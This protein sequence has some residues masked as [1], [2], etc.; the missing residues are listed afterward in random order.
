[1]EEIK[2][3]VIDKGRTYLYL[4]YTDPTTGKPVEK[5]A[6]TSKQADGIQRSRQMA[7]WIAVGDTRNRIAWRGKCSGSITRRTPCRRSHWQPNNV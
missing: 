3:Y 5:S 6:R 2:V 1:M 7:G 4:H